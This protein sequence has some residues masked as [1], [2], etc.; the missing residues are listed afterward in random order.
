M[1][2]G[3]IVNA[4]GAL[5]RL[6][7]TPLPV[8]QACRVNRMLCALEGDFR[9]WADRRAGVMAQYPEPRTPEQTGKMNRALEEILAVPSESGFSPVT[10]SAGDCAGM[11]ISSNDYAALEGFVRFSGMEDEA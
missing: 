11:R 8:R 10:L 7:A 1:T 2:L 3:T 9:D 4:Y 5:N 6:A